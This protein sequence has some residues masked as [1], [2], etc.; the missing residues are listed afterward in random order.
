MLL[1]KIKNKINNFLILFFLLA[2][3]TPVYFNKILVAI[4]FYLILIRFLRY[5]KILFSY[6]RLLIFFLIV[7]GII[8]TV[9]NSPQYL[10]RFII[11]LF[12]IFGFPFAK[13]K[14]D[15]KL[16]MYFSCLI[17]AY[18]FT[19]Q[20]LIAIGI[21][22][23]V[24]FRDTWYFYEDSW[25]FIENTLTLDELNIID[26]VSKE[27]FIIDFINF[28]RTYRPGGLFY[29]PN[30]LGSIILLYF[31]IFDECYSRQTKKNKLIYFFIFSLTLASLLFAF[32][33]TAISGFVIYL[34][35]KNFNFKKILQF[36]IHMQSLLIL[37]FLVLFSLFMFKYIIDGFKSD[38]SGYIKFF[39]LLN[40]L[41]EAD[42]LNIVFGGVHDNVIQFDNDLGNWIG[43]L[44]FVGLVG[45][46]L[47]LRKI[48][49]TN[50]TTL[51]FIFALV[52]MSIG[53]T[54]LY[55][56]LSGSIVFIYLLIIS[57]DSKKKL[58]S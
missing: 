44:G 12:I 13:F 58:Q 56:L 17:I 29:N 19:T 25:Y 20:M 39:I 33:R 14:L 11:I 30:V 32:S 16:I 23:A 1:M 42:L 22:W 46:I 41:K 3:I 2:T 24:S 48:I 36:Q 51:P 37:I 7:P 26:Y 15:K 10:I 45:L 50:K 4:A 18:L 38:E 5:G 40:Y 53:N 8:L 34:F 27:G 43:A 49:I 9:F 57:S 54:V 55:G 47:L 28:I 31:Y 52:I 6:D 35:I 21:D